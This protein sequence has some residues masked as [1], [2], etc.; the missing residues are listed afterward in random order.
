MKGKARFFQ[1]L[2]LAALAQPWVAD[3]HPFHWAS[4]SVG[5]LG[6]MIHPITSSE[7]VLTMLAI[8]LWTIQTGRRSAYYMPFVFVVLM[9]IG[10]GFTLIPIEIAYAENI[11]NLSILMLSLMLVL[12]FKVSSLVGVLVIGNV[13]LFHGYV[14][15]YDLL[16]DVGAVAYTAGFVLATVTL[17]ATGIATRVLLNRLVI[18]Y[19]LG[20]LAER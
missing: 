7:H 15:A 9:L 1:I 4:E 13:A 3:A 16:L 8:G 11:M 6:G 20:G 14:H 10:G 12:G 5:F 19:S 18:K 2:T 17:I